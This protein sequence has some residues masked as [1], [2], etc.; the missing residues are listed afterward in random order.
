MR[1]VSRA[2]AIAVLVVSAGELFARF[3]L[4]QEIRRATDID[5][6]FL[7]GDTAR[8]LHVVALVLAVA[9]LALALLT[10]GRPGWHWLAWGLFGGW[11]AYAYLT[12]RSVPRVFEDGRTLYM[13]PPAHLRDEVLH[14]FD[15]T[16]PVYVD[17]LGAVLL[18]VA[19]AVHVWRSSDRRLVGRVADQPPRP[20][21]NA[22]S[23]RTA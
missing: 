6:M 21:R 11:V 13:P 14:W 15:A 4:R 8:Q 16:I 3:A 17:L 1:S 23:R 5:D 20:V 2:A 19:V 12:A 9:A 10:G 18:V 7:F 22:R